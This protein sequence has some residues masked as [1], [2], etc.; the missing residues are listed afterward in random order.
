[1][2]QEQ[3]ANLKNLEFIDKRELKPD[4]W[5]RVGEDTLEG[6]YFRLLHNKLACAG[7]AQKEIIQLAADISRAILDGKE[8]E[9]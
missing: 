9:L 4:P 5:E 8:A 7:D 1:M 3:F 2:L 6:A